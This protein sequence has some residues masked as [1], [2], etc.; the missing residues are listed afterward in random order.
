MLMLALIACGPDGYDIDTWNSPLAQQ[1]AEPGDAAR[2]E[3]I[4]FNEHWEDAS[5]GLTCVSCHSADPGDSLTDD[6]D[7]YTRPAHTT[8]NA[9]YR[10]TWKASHP[11]DREDSDVNGAYGGQVCV[12]AYFPAGSAMTAQ[13]AADL[14][15]WMRDNRDADS[16]AETASELDY[17]FTSW[18]TQ[19]DFIASLDD[20]AGGVLAGEDIGD[21]SAGE[22]KTLQYCG[23]CHSQDG[24][25]VTLYSV[26]NLDAVALTQRIRKVEI[27]GVE[28][29]NDRMPRVPEDRLSDE[30]LADILAFLTTPDQ[31]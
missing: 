6:A 26:G 23:S 21:P 5:Y 3:E 25:T 9:A 14:E 10:E 17:G 24:A 30:D 15:A 1:A 28:A 18:D 29:P 19:E 11:W 2:G 16:S 7:D 20:G 22:A 4:Y 12:R 13:Q 8:W 27:D 31:T